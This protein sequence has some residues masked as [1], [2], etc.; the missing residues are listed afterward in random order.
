[1]ALAGCSSDKETPPAVDAALPPDAGVAD[2]SVPED[3]AVDTGPADVNVVDTS[4]ACAVPQV[5]QSMAC[6]ACLE[7]KC[8][9]LTSACLGDTAC[10][11]LDDCLYDCLTTNGGDAGSVSTC[12]QNCNNAQSKPTQQKWRSYNDCLNF[13]CVKNGNGPCQ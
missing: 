9:A 6:T 5:V 1:M 12:A 3:A 7:T 13:D 10:K 4:D 2:T 11:A 8:C